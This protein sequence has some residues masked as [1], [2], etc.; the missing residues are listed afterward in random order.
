MMSRSRKLVMGWELLPI[1]GLES[2]VS[3]H[4]FVSGH[5]NALRAGKGVIMQRYSIINVFCRPTIWPLEVA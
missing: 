4:C 3:Q 5:E 1:R 2:V